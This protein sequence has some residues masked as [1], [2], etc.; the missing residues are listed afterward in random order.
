MAIQPPNLKRTASQAA[1]DFP[2]A[3]KQQLG[4]TKHHKARWDIQSDYR[5]EPYFQDEK[6]PQDL[7]TRS[8]RLALEAVGFET[9][10]SGALE[11]FRMEVEECIVSPNIDFLSQC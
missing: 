2:A 9:A 1:F 10:E 4:V 6:V 8:I 3:K 5:Q 7:L 11:G